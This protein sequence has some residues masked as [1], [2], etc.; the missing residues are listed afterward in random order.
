MF[1]IISGHIFVL[2]MVVKVL[3]FPFLPGFRLMG[4]LRWIVH[5]AFSVEAR[6]GSTCPTLYTRR[7]FRQKLSTAAPASIIGKSPPSS[8]SGAVT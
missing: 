3:E 6:H 8:S 7:H 2:V 4:L 1:L 5:D